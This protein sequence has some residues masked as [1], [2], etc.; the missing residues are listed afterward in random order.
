MSN[1]SEYVGKTD[2]V[3]LQ[4]KTTVVFSG[5][6]AQCADWIL[7]LPEVIQLQFVIY[8]VL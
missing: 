5:T 3:V 6:E 1:I 4:N 2:C 8:T 7:V